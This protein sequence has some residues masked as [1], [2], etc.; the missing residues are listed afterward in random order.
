MG[1]GNPPA[2]SMCETACDVGWSPALFRLAQGACEAAPREVLLSVSTAVEVGV[3][4]EALCSLWHQQHSALVRKAAHGHRERVP[5]YVAAWEGGESLA[6][7]AARVGFSPAL[8]ARLVVEAFLGVAKKDVGE[9]VRRPEGIPNARLRAEVE[10][11]A[12]ADAHCGPR[13]DAARR[14]VGVEYELVLRSLLERSGIPFEH[15]DDLRQRGFSKT[16]DVHL[17][18]PL[19]FLR[20]GPPRPD[21]PKPRLKIVNWVDSK[22][23]FGSPQAYAT[24]VRHQLLAYVNRLGAG[25]VVFWFGFADELQDLDDDVLLLNDWPPAGALF[26][27]DATPVL[28]PPNEA[29]G[30]G[31]RTIDAYFP[32]RPS[33][34]AG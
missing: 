30:P 11:C 25:A 18:V 1:G 7:I 13:S 17:L 2:A 4:Y 23:M 3:G 16:P 29:Q 27:P 6:G 8:L 5:E 9:L 22:A 12:A 21:A 32:P 20:G 15:E 31:Q 14:D 19:G 24:E 26:W 33:P 34:P 10:A 28:P